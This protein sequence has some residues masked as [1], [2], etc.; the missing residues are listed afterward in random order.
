MGLLFGCHDV[1]HAVQVQA[2]FTQRFAVIRHVQ[3]GGGALL[4]F[5]P[6]HSFAQ[7]VVGIVH[8]IVVGVDDVL[9]GTILPTRFMVYTY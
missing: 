6:V 3:H 2:L 8:R 1:W 7:K 4:V 5:Q 9:G